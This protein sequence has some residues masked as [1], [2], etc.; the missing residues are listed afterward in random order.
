MGNQYPSSVKV[1]KGSKT[2]PGL[3]S[4]EEQS[5]YRIGRNVAFLLSSKEGQE[6]KKYF[7]GNVPDKALEKS[8]KNGKEKQYLISVIDKQS[9][10]KGRKDTILFLGTIPVMFCIVLTFK[11]N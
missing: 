2:K 6:I 5:D 7:G 9:K 1:I 4:F 10:T 3:I 8:M 11:S